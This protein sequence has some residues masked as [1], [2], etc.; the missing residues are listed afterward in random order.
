MI[1][2]RELPT[3]SSGYVLTLSCV[4]N[5]AQVTSLPYLPQGSSGVK[6]TV[7]VHE[8]SIG[9]APAETSGVRGKTED[10]IRAD[11]NQIRGYMDLLD[12]YSL[13]HFIIWRGK[14]I[15]DTPEFTSLARTHQACW[16]TIVRCV[17]LLEGMMSVNVV[18]LAVIDGRQLGELAK[19]DLERVDEADLW[20]CITN[21]EQIRPLL[22]H[23]TI[24]PDGPS[25]A[26]LAVLT[27]QA[28]ARRY[29][30]CFKYLDLERQHQAATKLQCLL[31]GTTSRRLVGK[32]LSRSR[33]RVET[34]WQ[35]LQDGLKKNWSR[36]RSNERV[37]I[38]LPA[39][40]TSGYAC[41]LSM[42]RMHWLMDPEVH[43]DCVV[44]SQ[45]D[46]DVREYH[47]KILEMTGSSHARGR[48]TV[49]VPENVDFFNRKLPLASLLLYSPESLKRI[50]KIVK[51]RHAM[52]ISSKVGWQDKRLAVALGVPLLSAEP[53]VAASLQTQSGMKRVFAAADVSA[54]VGAHDV[55]DE[56]DLLVSLTKL[57]ACNI[58]VRRWHIKMDDCQGSCGL[59]VL[60]TYSLT[61]MA[62]LKRE[63]AQLERTNGKSSEAWQHPDVQL[64][65]RAK[66]LKILR[67]CLHRVLSIYDTESYPTW[68]VFVKHFARIGGVI[69]AE[70][71]NTRSYPSSSV[72]ISPGGQITFLSETEELFD[73]F[74]R[75]VGCV[76]PQ[77]CV[78]PIALQGAS[79]A[80][81][82][83][84]R[85]RGVIGYVSISFVVFYDQQVKASRLWA[86]KLQLGLSASAFSFCLFRSLTRGSRP[87]QDLGC[88]SETRGLDELNE[89]GWLDSF[90]VDIVA[91]GRYI[92]VKP[93]L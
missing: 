15:R 45:P 10:T 58:E 75:K 69:D 17:N 5:T 44:P 19:F 46:N 30:A 64:L 31:R 8:I 25:K 6:Q 67:R 22:R 79:A 43:V 65:A 72:F 2:S 54:A 61:C 90:D 7:S 57:I 47:S 66:L 60:D 77:K 56:E 26:Q 28:A 14:A 4:L 70:A 33:E 42:S 92:I 87:G 48:V 36:C 88:Y 20:S 16:S 73:S 51:G 76:Q 38:L 71:P 40:T 74:Y 89:P 29:L 81:S 93:I 18:P 39:I 86:I 21:L 11:V 80:V 24:M 12:E 32:M 9:R 1:F 91:Y 35:M 85:S 37:L 34:T 13:H 41:D 83:E 63:K 3:Y 84:L 27:I 55:H 23:R 68:T 62:S 82:R 50:T 53:S 59:A 78:S 52:I 49:L